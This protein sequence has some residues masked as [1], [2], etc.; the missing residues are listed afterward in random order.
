A[1]IR[2]HV[3]VDV[4]DVRVGAAPREGQAVRL[5]V[6]G[7]DVAGELDAEVLHDAAVVRVVGV[8]A[9]TE[10]GARGVGREALDLLLTARGVDRRAAEHH[11]PAP[12]AR[13]ALA[14][15]LRRGHDDGGL[16]GPLRV[17]L[18]VPADDER[19]AAFTQNESP[20][21]NGQG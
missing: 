2:A 18:R 15:D 11:K 6:T 7:E 12:V 19:R 3:D 21:L 17:D 5:V 20:G 14:L 13:R 1:V 10:E 9:A 4:V 16:S 8:R